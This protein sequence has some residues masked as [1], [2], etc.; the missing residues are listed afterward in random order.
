[1][2]YNIIIERLATTFRSINYRVRMAMLAEV[3]C[4]SPKLPD[5]AAPYATASCRD[6][7]A[8]AAFKFQ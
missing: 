3:S 8:Q 7:G 1:M 6:N 4:G 5:A 2:Q